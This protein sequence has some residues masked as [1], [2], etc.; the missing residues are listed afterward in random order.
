MAV[1]ATVPAGPRPIWGFIAMIDAYA[2]GALRIAHNHVDAVPA[3][4]Q[5]LDRV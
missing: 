5:D 4:R 2:K 3:I 1:T